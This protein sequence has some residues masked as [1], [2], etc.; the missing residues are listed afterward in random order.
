M[1]CK[2]NC[3]INIKELKTIPSNCINF[4]GTHYRNTIKCIFRGLCFTAIIRSQWTSY[5]NS[6]TAIRELAL[7]LLVSLDAWGMRHTRWQSKSTIGEAEKEE[8]ENGKIETK[9]SK[10]Q[11]WQ[12]HWQLSLWHWQLSTAVLFLGLF[13][14][15]YS[16]LASLAPAYS[17]CC[18][19]CFF[20][21]TVVSDGYFPAASAAVAEA[22]A[23]VAVA[24]PSVVVVIFLKK[25]YLD[26]SLMCTLYSPVSSASSYRWHLTFS[27]A[28]LL[29]LLLISNIAGTLF[30]VYNGKY[31]HASNARQLFF[32]LLIDLGNG[33]LGIRLP[34]QRW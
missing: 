32:A 15:L 19:C 12:W 13:L 25:C 6:T 29:I 7:Y 21:A 5:M 11:Q 31:S 10:K 20:P 24:A 4:Q 17:Y 16:L 33:I 14:F 26:F 22:A 23:A 8:N 2:L 9:D 30:I 3:L 34:A 28:F 18:F 1:E 27:S